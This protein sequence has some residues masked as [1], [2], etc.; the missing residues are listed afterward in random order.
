MNIGPT[1][2][3]SRTHTCLSFAVTFGSLFCYKTFA[4]CAKEKEACASAKFYMEDLRPLKK[5]S[6]IQILTSYW[7]FFSHKPVENP[8]GNY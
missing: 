2:M 8:G 5:I 4:T 1:G 6:R 7:Y 3:F